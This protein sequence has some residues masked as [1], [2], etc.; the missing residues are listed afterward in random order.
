M[1]YRLFLIESSKRSK[2]LKDS[3]F[4]DVL[5]ILIGFNCTQILGGYARGYHTRQST[6]HLC[7]G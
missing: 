7:P 5:I 4:F 1:I 3:S 6:L 2:L